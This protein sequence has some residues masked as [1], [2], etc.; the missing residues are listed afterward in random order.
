M[1]KKIF[2]VMAITAALIA[3]VCAGIAGAG[4]AQGK[5]RAL[6]AMSP[7]EALAYMKAAEDLVIIDTATAR[8]YNEK[9]FKG[10]INIH[11]SEM[12]RRCGEIPENSVVLLHCRLGMVVPRAYDVLLEKRPDLAEISYI[13]GAPL[14]D[15]Y[16]E[17]AEEHGKSAQKRQSER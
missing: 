10:A 6:G 16:N 2:T 9:H 13:D 4:S 14:F 3:C 7:Q 1:S 17:W 8:E 15:E 5:T 12:P 11:Y